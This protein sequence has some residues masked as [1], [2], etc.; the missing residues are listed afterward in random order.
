M[1]ARSSSG[2]PAVTG[3]A[4]GLPRLTILGPLSLECDGVRLDLGAP[5]QQ[6]VLVELA[7]G[8]A[9]FMATSE[10][11]TGLWGDH[12]PATGEAVIRTY[13]SR[14]RRLLADNGLGDAIVFRS[15]GY[16][17]DPAKFVVDAAEFELLIEAARRERAADAPEAAADHVREALALWRG[18]APAGVPGHAAERER[19]RLERLRLLAT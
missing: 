3:S 2:E 14:L 15:G 11:V 7:V 18:T 16:S 4:C 1:H 17:L 10:L 9:R 12:A 19:M 13:I 5:Q 8:R 6:A